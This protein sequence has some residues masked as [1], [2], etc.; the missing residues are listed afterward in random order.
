MIPGYKTPHL[1]LLRGEVYGRPVIGSGDRVLELGA[2]LGAVTEVLADAA[3]RVTAYEPGPAYEVAA[4]RVAGRDNAR[5]VR[6]AVVATGY[7]FPTLTLNL[8]RDP[9]NVGPEA[10]FYDEPVGTV[11]VPAVQLDEAIREASASA[12]VMDIEGAEVDLLT[13]LSLP[14]AVRTL[15]VEWHPHLAGD[16][17]VDAAQRAVAAMGFRRLALLR[18]QLAPGGFHSLAVYRR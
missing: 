16:E 11:E 8:T 7:T 3:D 14:V 6:A 9:W 18:G 2:C 15:V 17:P 13:V 1:A 5:V 12:V 4:A 10:A